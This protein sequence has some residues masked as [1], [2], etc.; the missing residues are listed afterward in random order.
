MNNVI[1]NFFDA[2]TCYLKIRDLQ[3]V[4]NVT[5]CKSLNLYNQL[6]DHKYVK[7]TES[8]ICNASELKIKRYILD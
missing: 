3:P 6:V 7:K 4:K 2:F 8:H 5:S 1:Q